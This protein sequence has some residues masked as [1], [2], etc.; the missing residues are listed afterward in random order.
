MGRA[1]YYFPGL[2]GIGA[3][4]W[5][6]GLSG[7]SWPRLVLVVVAVAVAYLGAVPLSANVTLDLFIGWH[8]PLHNGSRASVQY[9]IA[10]ATFQTL[11]AGILVAV[12]LLAIKH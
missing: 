10:N 3:T 7:L 4:V 9:R 6:I 8:L 1:I 11:V 12:M 2:V 5:W